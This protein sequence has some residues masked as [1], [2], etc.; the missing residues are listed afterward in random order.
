VGDLSSASERTKTERTKKKGESKCIEEAVLLAP[1]KEKKRQKRG[2][3]DTPTS[4][5]HSTTVR[6]H[7]ITVVVA[8]NTPARLHDSRALVRSTAHQLRRNTQM[9]NH[10]HT[11]THTQPERSS[12]PPRHIPLSCLFFGGVCSLTMI[13]RDAVKLSRQ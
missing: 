11:H 2:R 1:H 9:H 10:T 13:S 8:A 12:V 3:S 7:Y 4:D 6:R 5:E